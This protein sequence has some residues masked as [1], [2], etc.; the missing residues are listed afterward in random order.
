MSS[1]LS[2]PV[3]TIVLVERPYRNDIHP[4]AASAMSYDSRKSSAPTPSTMVMASDVHNATGIDWDEAEHWFRDSWMYI[5]SGT[6]LVNVCCFEEFMGNSLNER[7]AVESFIR[8]MIVLSY[9]IHMTQ[10]EVVA[11]GNPA[12]SSAN[13]IRA[14]IPDRSKKV[15]VR[16]GPNPAGLRHKFGDLKSPSITLGSAALSKVLYVAIQR[17][18]NYQK[19]NPEDFNIMT[20]IKQANTKARLSTAHRDFDEDLQQ[21]EMFFKSGGVYEG[22]VS[23]EQVFASLRR[24]ASKFVDVLTEERVLIMLANHEENTASAKGAYGSGNRTYTPKPFN[25]GSS[26]EVSGASKVKPAPTQQKLKFADDDTETPTNL[27]NT[28]SEASGTPVPTPESSLPQTPTHRPLRPAAPKSASG[29]TAVSSAKSA[30]KLKF[31]DEDVED[32]PTEEESDKGLLDEL[33]S[34]EPVKVNSAKSSS[35]T[36]TPSQ[37]EQISY[38]AEF[39]HSDAKYGI[40]QSVIQEINESASTGRVS[41]DA[42]KKVLDV[43]R[44]EGSD[45]AEDLGYISGQPKADSL[46]MQL[47]LSWA[48]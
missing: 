39:L 12:T 42:S 13:R 40:E 24:S 1:Q 23:D 21:V 44:S 25:K 28:V 37:V 36:M 38:V 22:P 47:L 43:I 32:T 20:T 18:H 33:D 2:I 41:S 14:N 17:S 4:H 11:L 48:N 6:F 27:P 16:R 9:S 31:I 5:K 10:V 29:Q 45:M 19:C 46:I 8:D 7:V 34:I 35:I 3:R 26:S 15:I 30:T